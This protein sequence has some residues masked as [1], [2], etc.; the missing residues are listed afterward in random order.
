MHNWNI[1]DNTLQS[2]NILPILTE[3]RIKKAGDEN[4][5]HM[6]SLEGWRFTTKL[7]PHNEWQVGGILADYTRFCQ[8]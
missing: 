8:T 1:L 7:R 2:H 5:T 4:R 6:A 3:V